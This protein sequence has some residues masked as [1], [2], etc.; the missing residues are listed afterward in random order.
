MGTQTTTTT[1]PQ[2][3]S[4][5]AL[6]RAVEY[7]DKARRMAD[8]GVRTAEANAPVIAVYNSLATVYA[9]VAKA[10]AALTTAQDDNGK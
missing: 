10:A 6:T 1:T 9:D 5:R 7:A 3:I 2:D 4:I 8:P